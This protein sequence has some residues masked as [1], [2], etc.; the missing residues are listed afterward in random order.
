MRY[1]LVKRGAQLLSSLT[2]IVV[3]LFSV[4]HAQGMSS[5]NFSN[6]MFMGS[7]SPICDNSK[8][9]SVQKKQ[10][11]QK[12]LEIN[13][14]NCMFMGED[15]V[16]CKR[17]KLSPRQKLQVHQ[18]SLKL[19]FDTCMFMG[20]DWLQ[21]NKSQLS[22]QQAREVHQNSLKLNFDTCKFMGEDW[23]H[24]KKSQLSP[25]QR[26]VVRR[27][28][29]EINF[30]WCSTFGTKSSFCKKGEL[31]R[32]QIS[33]I[34]NAERNLS[35][36]EKYLYRNQITNPAKFSKYETLEFKSILGFPKNENLRYSPKFDIS[37]HTFCAE[38][39]SCR[40][41]ISF[42]TGRPKTIFITGYNRK[43]GTYVR[44]HYRSKR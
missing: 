44:S 35:N 11:Q 34:S 2:I 33:Q 43:D 23:I 9:S 41:D 4:S 21:C 26:K 31:T 17:S 12:T 40:G 8:L 25:E 32:T 3:M 37:K 36:F 5:T 28:S 10:V 38:N 19:N 6:C 18:N 42:I 29:L 20:E 13:F 30:Q 14:S 15:S 7:D 22:P 27:A 39:G 24:C 16:I 1:L